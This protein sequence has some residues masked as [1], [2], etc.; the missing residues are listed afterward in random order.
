M[1]DAGTIAVLAPFLMVVGIVW[2]TSRAKLEEKRIAAE[3]S[4]RV[5]TA[6]GSPVSDRVD[7]LEERVRILERIVTDGS[8]DLAQKIEALRDERPADLK[9]ASTR[10]RETI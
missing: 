1:F 5:Q 3:T 10:S 9:L 7:E 6:A 2:V 8:Y 4:A